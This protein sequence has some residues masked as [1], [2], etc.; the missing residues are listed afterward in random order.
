MKST[1][2]AKI[3]SF[4]G[5]KEGIQMS[6]YLSCSKHGQVVHVTF[7]P[8]S[9]GNIVP[10]MVGIKIE[11]NIRLNKGFFPGLSREEYSSALSVMRQMF[12]EQIRDRFN[13]ALIKYGKVISGY[14]CTIDFDIDKLRGNK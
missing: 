9:E 1:V 11:S 2:N 7:L 12:L 3:G 5:T 14:L 10:P 8:D 4:I 13:F 6:V